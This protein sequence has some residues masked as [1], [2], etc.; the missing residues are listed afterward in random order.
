MSL[1]MF[2]QSVGKIKKVLSKIKKR[3][4]WILRPQNNKGGQITTLHGYRANRQ[5]S[6]HQNQ[7]TTDN[8]KT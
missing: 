8:D 1:Q 7:N 4:T 6:E 5:S 3:E 2:E